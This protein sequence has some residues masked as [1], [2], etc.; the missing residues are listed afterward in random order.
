M[1]WNQ[2]FAQKTIAVFAAGVAATRAVL[3]VTAPAHSMAC[4]KARSPATVVASPE[5]HGATP[6]FNNW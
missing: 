4:H 3:T 1:A 2:F 6:A 5:L